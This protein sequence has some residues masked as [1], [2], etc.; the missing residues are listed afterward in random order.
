MTSILNNENSFFSPF[1][2]STLLK[3][4]S[5]YLFFYFFGLLNFEV[6]FSKGHW[7]KAN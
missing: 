7:G 5:F 1:L 3:C 6:Y 4:N 2:S